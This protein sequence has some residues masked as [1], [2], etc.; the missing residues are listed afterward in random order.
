MLMNNK[1]LLI[2]LLI[3]FIPGCSSHLGPQTITADRFDYNKTIT[4]SWKEQTLLN[5]IKLRYADMPLFVEVASLVSGYTLE[6]TVNAGGALSTRSIAGD[7][8]SL[9]ASAKYID[10]PTITY[11]PITGAKF[12]KSFMTP[13]PPQAVLYL[14]MSG[15]PA[16]MVLNLTVEAINGYRS[17]VSAGANQRDGDA[18][19]YRM[20]ELF[21]II[22]KSGAVAMRVQKEKSTQDKTVM[23]L[24]RKNIDIEIIKAEEEL[25][26]LLEIR[27]QLQEIDIIYGL[28]SDSDT[29]IALLTRSMLSVMIELA[30]KVDVP[31]E[32]V[33]SGST[34][35]SLLQNK[36][37]LLKVRTSKE[38]P[39]NAFVAVQYKDHW[40][41][42]ADG[43]FKSKRTFAFVMIL[44]SLTET[45][46]KGNLPVITIPTG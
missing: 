25:N 23:L 27:P 13:I 35:P 42:I 40:F 12:S 36:E 28:M 29:E 15:W 16:D 26:Q 7:V 34:V 41:W 21:H 11:I 3:Q 5:I 39:D 43:D 8:V 45:G 2:L 44:F 20:V 22:Q 9:G 46:D 30:T 19:Y 37:Q 24:Q 6:T 33:A 1:Y 18:A 32:H 31:P 14:M 17:E 10:R 4:D 38:K